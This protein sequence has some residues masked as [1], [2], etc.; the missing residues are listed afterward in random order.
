[1]KKSPEF[2]NAIVT[3]A[4]VL[5]GIVPL[6][7]LILFGSVPSFSAMQSD[8]SWSETDIIL[9]MVFFLG[10]LVIGSVSTNRTRHPMK[11]IFA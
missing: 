3:A 5:F 7:G 6:I 8:A 1:M 10:Y 11:K 2:F 4:F 9:G